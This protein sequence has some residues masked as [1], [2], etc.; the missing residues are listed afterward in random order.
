MHVSRMSGNRTASQKDGI[1]QEMLCG[2]SPDL[3]LKPPVSIQMAEFWAKIHPKTENNL[4]RLI[5]G[6]TEV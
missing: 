6:N 4:W 3:P 5:Y 2:K 1:T